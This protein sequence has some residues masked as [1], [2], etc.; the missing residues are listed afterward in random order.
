MRGG[1]G[2]SPSRRAGSGP[3]PSRAA[4]VRESRGVR[5][6][7]GGS[8]PGEAPW[9]ARSLWRWA[10]TQRGGEAPAPFASWMLLIPSLATSFFLSFLS[11]F[12]SLP[13][14][15]PQPPGQRSERSRAL[16]AP[17]AQSGKCGEGERGPG[18]A[19]TRPPQPR[20]ILTATLEQKQRGA[21]PL[22][23]SPT[24]S[25]SQSCSWRPRPCLLP[26]GLR[27]GGGG[28][29]APEPG[30]ESSLA[31]GTLPARGLF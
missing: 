4:A 20:H 12:N 1:G 19:P 21:D 24:P 16:R 17:G 22:A 14:A 8:G 29:A 5:C 26:P 7:H 25:A 13:S 27:R 23:P 28:R 18:A 31:A 9:S 11:L 30:E 10:G 2:S 15:P 3:G 6:L